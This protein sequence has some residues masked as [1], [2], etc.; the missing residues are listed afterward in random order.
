MDV[1]GHGSGL[2]PRPA[3]FGAAE[4]TLASRAPLPIHA[5]PPFPIKGVS[6]FSNRKPLDTRRHSLRTVPP[7]GL[8]AA[9][10]KIF[11]IGKPRLPRSAERLTIRQGPLATMVHTLIALAPS[12]W[13]GPRGQGRVHSVERHQ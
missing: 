10:A 12:W 3:Y 9:P 1:T 6:G 13:P 5:G 11:P 2:N 4:M 7:R 8:E